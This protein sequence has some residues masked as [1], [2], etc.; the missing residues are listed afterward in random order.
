MHDAGKA[1]LVLSAVFMAMLLFAIATGFYASRTAHQPV[2]TT[3]L[4]L[5][6]DSPLY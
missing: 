3:H 6:V 1:V 4:S 2:A 5:L